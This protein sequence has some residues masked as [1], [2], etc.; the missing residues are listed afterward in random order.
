MLTGLCA[1]RVQV[2]ASQ[3]DYEKELEEFCFDEGR[4][5]VLL[6]NLCRGVNLNLSRFSS[7]YLNHCAPHHTIDI[8]EQ[9]S[10]S[11]GGMSVMDGGVVVVSLY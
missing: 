11:G 5:V 1:P 10:G 8:R 9:V 4:P 3:E 2:N 6:R 7:I